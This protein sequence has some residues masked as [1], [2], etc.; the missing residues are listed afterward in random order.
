MTEWLNEQVAGIRARLSPEDEGA[1]WLLFCSDPEGDALLAVSFDD[2]IDNYD[3]ELLNGLATVLNGIGV[4]SVLLA[5]I[6]RKGRPSA[7]EV[8]LWREIKPLLDPSI[9]LIDLVV[10]GD[11]TYWSARKRTRRLIELPTAGPAR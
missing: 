6:R 5:A 1:L 7:V 9:E 10:V 2:F 4:E 3:A 8:R 11:D